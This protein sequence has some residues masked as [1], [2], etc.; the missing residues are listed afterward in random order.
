MADF[1]T[2]V[3]VSTTLGVAYGGA[4]YGLFGFPPETCILAG[5]LCSVSGMLPDIDSNSGRPLRESLAFMAA[6]IPMMLADRMRS[7]GCSPEITIMT[8]A[9]VYLFVR[10]GLGY[11]LKRYTVHRGMFHSLPA[12]LIFGELAFLL[13]SGDTT[14]IR[15]YKASAV[16][17]GYLSHLV[18]D[19]I[20]SV[21]WRRG[22]LRIKKSFGTA[23]KM[24]STKSLWANLSV[25]VKLALLSYVVFYEPGW[26]YQFRQQRAERWNSH[27]VERPADIEVAG[28]VPVEKKLEEVKTEVEAKVEKAKEQTA[29]TALRLLEEWKR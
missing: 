8:G 4:A 25:Y 23:V 7:M 5:S 29:N 17:L 21:E 18:L 10:F 14:Y 11:F 20:Y 26:M 9:L 19:E 1:K 15:A 12:V 24:Y 2:H 6:V 27:A 13:A 22:W 3:T 16:M 28:D